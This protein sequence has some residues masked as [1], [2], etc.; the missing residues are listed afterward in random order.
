MRFHG[1]ID[2]ELL[3]V[4]A[5]GALAGIRSM[6]PHAVIGRA[7]RERPL[8]LPEPFSQL[9]SEPALRALT[10][11]ALM[12]IASDKLPHGPRRL[13]PVPLLGRVVS[14]AAAGFV[15]GR[16]RLR[17]PTLFAG[18][19]AAAAALAAF[20]SHHLRRFVTSRFG[21]SNA[22]AGAMEDGLALLGAQA[23]SKRLVR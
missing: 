23:V 19:G 13:A 3:T 7:L 15:T 8:R 1:K 14:G 4:V 10:T 22:S 18:L 11:A 17:N 9:T 5:L 16:Q 6:L 12:E 21:L 20:G 2:P